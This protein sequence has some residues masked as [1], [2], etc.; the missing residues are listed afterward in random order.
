MTTFM[1]AYLLVWLAVLVYVGHLGVEQRRL[2]RSLD[3]LRDDTP[4]AVS[5][6]ETP[7]KA[8]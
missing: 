1:A 2:Q 3:T 4:D 5:E 8:A 6:T 7:A